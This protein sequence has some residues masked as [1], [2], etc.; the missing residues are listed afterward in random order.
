MKPFG[1][2]R[3]GL[4]LL[5]PALLLAWAPSAA[6]QEAAEQEAAEEEPAV[7]E[8]V[9]TATR[10]AT[11]I[12]DVPYNISAVDGGVVED[13]QILDSAELLRNFAGVGT[14][15]RGYRNSGTF[16]AIRL[17]GLN[18]DHSGQGDY[19]VIADAT[20]ATYVNDTPV[21]ANFLLKDLERVEVLRGPQG[22]LY[23]S[24]ALAGAVRYILRRPQLE[25]FS[26]SGSFSYSTTRGSDGENL[27]LDLTLNAPVGDT[28]ALRLVG[29]SFDYD[30]LV[31][32]VSL[33]E[34][35]G[36]GVPVAPA[37][38]LDPA[39]SYTAK[40]DADSVDVQFVRASLLWEPS[41]SLAVVFS[42]VHQEDEIG[43]RRQTTPNVD[44]YGRRYGRF[45]N[46]SPFLEPAWRYMS[47]ASVEL[48]FN[49]G[50]FTLSSSTAY[51]EHRGHAISDNTGFYAKALVWP[52]LQFL[53]GGVQVPRPAYSTHRHYADEAFTQELRL[54][55][56]GGRRF[57]YVLGL[58]YKK[59]D[60]SNLE[61][62]HL[63][64]IT[65]FMDA[66]PD[67]LI[68]PQSD[69]NFHFRNQEDFSDLAAFGDLS[70]HLSDALRATFGLRYFNNDSEKGTFMDLLMLDAVP[71]I[72]QLWKTS[73]NDVLFKGS[74][75]WDLSE[76]TM[77]YGTV[78]E[79]YRRGG[80]NAVPLSGIYGEDPAWQEYGS[81]GVVNYELGVKGARGAFRY[82]A[83]LYYVDWNDAQLNTATPNGG[84]Y[85]AQNADGAKTQ[86]IELELAGNL[87]ENLSFSLGYAYVDAQL[88]ADFLAPH[89]DA[90]IAPDG[91]R[92]PGSAEHA[93]N[94]AVNFNAQL[95]EDI[96]F[97][98][99]VNGYYQSSTLGQV[100]PGL[101]CF[102]FSPSGGP[103]PCYGS[104]FDGFQIWNAV[105][106]LGFGDWH[107]SL[108]G[109]NLFNE[110][111]ISGTFSED[112]S[113]TFPAV[114]FYG[115]SARQMIALPRTFGLTLN[116]RF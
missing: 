30:G 111:G 101:R 23:G 99:N 39:A 58:F 57:D 29:S 37:G 84:F 74:L 14:V 31:D 35:D 24:G 91:A 61:L 32:Y 70:W 104:E 109:K 110:L 7:E 93:F 59:Q 1:D 100:N 19:P 113:G 36:D 82:G 9:V 18:L 54:V 67:S 98:G 108:W 34:L 44:G 112:F 97:F 21:F 95:T 28:A 69:L 68:N 102:A 47:L 52:Y 92:L 27:T 72:E 33:Y 78:S 20:V 96:A 114:G 38:L 49:L 62:A 2:C 22:T 40:K 85:A 5:C 11:S 65:A 79:G 51:Y 116:Y 71:A 16:N 45:E 107:A 25:R 66:L 76:H 87:G 56:D 8:I 6:G 53:A 64:G 42:A 15:D 43:G 75:A 94:A 89:N 13:N 81:D 80:T 41:E 86:G 10:R 60:L 88:T 26:G 48:E 83:A 4:C 77:L 90:L 12:Q 3:F 50:G 55:S 103:E 17:R 73:D 63:R 106:T 46:G 115:N 105:G